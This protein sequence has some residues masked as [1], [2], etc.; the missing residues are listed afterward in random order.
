[1]FELCLGKDNGLKATD[2]C[3]CEYD[4]LSA[5]CCYTIKTDDP[6]GY[7]VVSKQ[8]AL[9]KYNFDWEKLNN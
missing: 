1:M 6:E 7:N 2:V 3:D 5:L 9:S 8:E 4:L